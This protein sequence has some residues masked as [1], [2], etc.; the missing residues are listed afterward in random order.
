MNLLKPNPETGGQPQPQAIRLEG[1]AD[2]SESLRD[3]AIAGG[4]PPRAEA[5]RFSYASGSRPLEGYTIKRGVGRGGFG[6]VYYA[7]SDAGKEVAL[8]LIR[9]NLEIELRGVSQCLNLKHPHLVSLYDIRTDGNEDRWV[10]ME[11]VAGENLDAIIERH[12]DGLPA[13]QTLACFRQ[14]AAGVAHLHDQGIVHRDL[15]PG[16]VFLDEGTYKIGDYG[17]SKFISASRRSGQTESIGTVHYMAPEIANGRYGKEID[18]YALGIILYEMLSGRVPYE[19]ETLGE[20]LMKHLTAEPDLSVLPKDYRHVVARMLC[21]NPDQRYHSVA[22]VLADLEAGPQHLPDSAATSSAN[23]GQSPAAQTAHGSSPRSSNSSK[24]RRSAA[25]VKTD[26]LML[27]SDDA[28]LGGVCGGFAR[29]AGI[30]PVWI[31]LGVVAAFFATGF[32][33]VL[34]PYFILM[35]VMPSDVEEIEPSSAMFDSARSVLKSRSTLSMIGGAFRMLLSLVFGLGFGLLAGGGT[36][37]ALG[38]MHEEI[39]VTVGIAS[40][41]FS[42]AAMATILGAHRLTAAAKIFISLLVAAGLGLSVAAGLFMAGYTGYSNDEFVIMT[43]VGCG[44]FVAGALI[45]WRLAATA[46]MIWRFFPPLLL[47]GGTGMLIGG[48]IEF[49]TRNTDAAVFLGSGAGILVFGFTAAMLFLGYF[50]PARAEARKHARYNETQT[51]DSAEVK[52]YA[53]R[54]GRTNAILIGLAVALGIIP[55]G[56][57]VVRSSIAVPEQSYLIQTDSHVHGQSTARGT[58]CDENNCGQLATTLVSTRSNF[59]TSY[60]RQHLCDV[61]ARAAA[62]EAKQA[63]IAYEIFDIKTGGARADLHP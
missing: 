20:V 39:A 22:E 63:G 50:S 55:A 38:R 49:A 15:K 5:M 43:S 12:P 28:V 60:Q 18:I 17:L 40:G 57:F 21:K 48:T 1:A 51:W 2:L 59:N 56:L 7:I 29:Y 27:A 54:P 58:K 42:A 11:Y 19:G 3:T 13:E 6:E 46:G 37:L 62:W 24:P 33:P 61:H 25:Y 26:R 52:E 8:K 53:A 4:A 31:R 32:V 9:R 16:N 45:V 47:G 44:F 36:A 34:V 14:I 35:C 23:H 30:D 41:C 10:I